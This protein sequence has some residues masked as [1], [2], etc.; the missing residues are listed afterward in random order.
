MITYVNLPKGKKNAFLNKVLESQKHFQKFL[1]FSKQHPRLALFSL[2]SFL[3]L[4]M[5]LTVF[6]AVAHKSKVGFLVGKPTINSLSSQNNSPSSLIEIKGKR[7]GNVKPSKNLTYPGGVIFTGSET[8]VENPEGIEAMIV[9]WSD[10]KITFFVPT[11]ALSGYIYVVNREDGD[12]LRFSNG[13][14]FTVKKPEP[15]II[16]L[17]TS[18]SRPSEIVTIKGESLGNFMSA[19][20]QVGGTRQPTFPGRVV[21]SENEKSKF[22]VPVL[23]WTDDQIDFY[24]P[25]SVKAGNI[26]VV[27]SYNDTEVRSNSLSLNIDPPT[28]EVAG[29]EREEG[30]PT[31]LV[32]IRG[33][34]FGRAITN[35]TG[36]L[37]YPGRVLFGQNEGV[38]SGWSPDTI[39][40]YVPV[41]AKV[42]S[43]EVLV[44][45]DYLKD[46]GK[47]NSLSFNVKTPDP[48]LEEGVQSAHPSEAITIRGSG[49]GDQISSD[50]LGLIFPGKVYFSPGNSN[51]PTNRSVLAPILSWNDNSI[52]VNVPVGV[53]EGKMFIG[54][55]SGNGD[56]FSEGLPFAPKIP[57]PEI[58]SISTDNVL[59]GQLIEIYGKNFGTQM[60]TTR[61]AITYPG[62]VYINDKAAVPVF[63]GWKEDRI[64]VYVP[65]GSKSGNIKVSLQSGNKTVTSNEKELVVQT[66]KIKIDQV[67]LL[68]PEKNRVSLRG[69]G[70]GGVIHNPY[71][72]TFYPGKVFLSSV[73]KAE[74]SDNKVLGASRVEAKV[75]TW[76]EDKLILTLPKNAKKGYLYVSVEGG[77]GTVLSNGSQFDSGSE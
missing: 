71:I 30:L 1:T 39:T 42:G 60:G 3:V 69:E 20:K 26:E 11:E 38:V 64:V 18:T 15:K 62:K 4:I 19:N 77:E 5:G 2:L 8:P 48:K 25:S 72:G 75:E 14:R 45:V 74:G 51:E 40:A 31:E 12:Y 32:T 7:F 33:E 55:S 56:Y 46:G 65:W 57:E 13:Q 47:S 24:T 35:P 44:V 10:T 28:P 58:D 37:R 63:G 76:L 36:L 61:T 52:Q 68:D 29:L 16:S 50:R 53:S 49:F 54:R 73:E 21:I 70:F 67:T 22:D 59:P 66:P 17:S 23:S 41:G 6:A 34:N 43:Q 9:S 27:L